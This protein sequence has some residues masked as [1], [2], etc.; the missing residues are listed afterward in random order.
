[1][2]KEH[3]SSEPSLHW[4]KLYDPWLKSWLILMPIVGAGSYYLTR[5][6]WRRIQ[7]I[8]NGEAGSVWDAPPVPEVSEPAS[9]V[10]YGIVA[11]IIFS[12]FWMII[13]RLYVAAQASQRTN[14]HNE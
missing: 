1:M 14:K 5:N 9:F 10:S 7:A 4:R 11:S 6:A 8:L 2:K 3:T 13:A 12:L